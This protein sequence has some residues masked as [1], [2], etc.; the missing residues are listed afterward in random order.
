[1]FSKYIYVECF[2]CA[3]SSLLEKTVRLVKV[4]G[5]RV[6]IME[7]RMGRLVAGRRE[8]RASQDGGGRRWPIR[9]TVHDRQHQRQQTVAEPNDMTNVYQLSVH[10]TTTSTSTSP[11]LALSSINTAK[12]YGEY[13][14]CLRSETVARTNKKKHRELMNS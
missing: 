12:L 2:Y 5:G 7:H 9:A 4:T 3:E 1:M 14:S 8:S 6:W 10:S 11:F 13:Y